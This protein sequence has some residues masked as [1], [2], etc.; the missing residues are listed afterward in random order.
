[1]QA[2]SNQT[3]QLTTHLAVEKTIDESNKKSLERAQEVG[4][5]A[6][7]AEFPHCAVERRFNHI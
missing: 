2:F 1:M 7:Q 6:P 3:S 4:A 5:V